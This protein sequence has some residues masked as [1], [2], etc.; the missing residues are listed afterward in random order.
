[1]TVLHRTGGLV[2]LSALCIAA[3]AASQGEAYSMLQRYSRGLEV[4]RAAYAA[5]GGDAFDALPALHI[6]LEGNNL[7]R[8]QS[9]T[10]DAEYYPGVL[11]RDSW[12]DLAAS[13]VVVQQEYGFPGGVVF[14]TRFVIAG[15][16]AYSIDRDRAQYVRLPAGAA[17]GVDFPYRAIPHFLLRRALARRQTLRWLGES[18]IDGRVHDVIT[19][20]WGNGTVYTLSVDRTSGLPRTVEW[21]GP[22]PV[23]GAAVTTFWFD[24]YAFVRSVRFPRR[25]RATIADA[26]VQRG[27]LSLE[28]DTGFPT[29]LL[30]VE[31]EFRPAE[32]VSPS[33]RDLGQGAYLIEHLGASALGD[34]KVL[35][36]DLGEAVAVIDAPLG[37]PAG[38]LIL[39]QIDRTLPGKPVSHVIL[40]H[41]HADHT[42]G[43]RPFIAAGAT[44]VTTTGNREFFE[45]LA[46]ASYTLG[47][48][49]QDRRRANPRFIF[50]E[51]RLTLGSGDGRLELFRIGPTPHVD[52]MFVAY[53][54]A[55]RTLF[56]SDLVIDGKPDAEITA[57]FVE[58]LD[59]F[60]RPVARIVGNHHLD[61]TPDAVR[62]RVRNVGGG[63]AS[64][65]RLSR[66]E[67]ER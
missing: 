25:F 14:H 31:S 17:A 65:V 7:G 29:P 54:P 38:E 32:P 62:E 59:R 48:D 42:G 56:G 49:R 8:L 9:E 10:P 60:D 40:T 4:A 46:H 5:L 57:Y 16:T 34:Y 47:P 43:V 51:D 50:V 13:R 61:T 22:D 1:M 23:D 52:D 35:F 39:R 37:S 12:Y 64:R 18:T 53:L 26:E 55:T 15:D 20:E 58:W 28:A 33:V 19:F 6:H 41:Y 11:V 27:A 36:V 67:R 44:L 63:R 30:R 45:Q 21:L 24:D 66:A 3:P 2:W